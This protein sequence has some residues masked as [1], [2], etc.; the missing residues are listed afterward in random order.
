FCENFASRKRLEAVMKSKF[1]ASGFLRWLRLLMMPY[2]H[3][4][5][6]LEVLVN[7]K[8]D[9]IEGDRLLLLLGTS[10]LLQVRTRASIV[11]ESNGNKQPR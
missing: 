2:F 9:W 11:G 4:L 5:A 1:F 10:N 8:K 6:R 7:E 3:S